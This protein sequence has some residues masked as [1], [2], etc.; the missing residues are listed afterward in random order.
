MT[1]SSPLKILI[2]GSYPPPYGGGSVYIQRLFSYMVRRGHTCHIFDACNGKEGT[3]PPGVFKIDTKIQMYFKILVSRKYDILHINES[4]WKHRAI[5]VLLAKLKGMQSI[6]TLHS[7]R[8]T[9]QTMRA[10]DRFLMTYTLK[11]VDCIVSSGSRE[12]ERVRRWFPKRENTRVITPFI[13]PDM[14]SHRERLPEIIASFLSCH[15]TVVCANGSNLDFFNGEDIYGLDMAVELCRQ[16]Q[17][18]GDIGIIYCLTRITNPEYFEQIRERI[19][20]YQLEQQFLI[21]TAP[22]EFWQVIAESAVFIRPTRT[23]SFGISV[24][25]GILLQKPTIASDACDRPRGTILFRSGD[26]ADLLEKTLTVLKRMNKENDSNGPGHVA[27]GAPMIEDLY[28]ELL[29]APEYMARLC[30]GT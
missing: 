19:A 14:N 27:D 21:Y 18:T 11:N 28:Y 29:R 10:V 4:M 8:E 17:E 6:L 1:Q 20:A 26:Q 2:T 12:I 16:L 30:E 15:E 25:E 22:V 5:L 24:A 23:D 3:V 9:R 13:T 7:L